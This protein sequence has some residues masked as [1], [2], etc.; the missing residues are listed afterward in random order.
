MENLSDH[1]TDNA[2]QWFDDHPRWTRHFT[3]K[4]ASWLNQVE[5]AFSILQSRVI[6]RGS[7]TSKDDLRDKIYAYLGWHNQTDQP[8]HWIGSN[9]Q[10]PGQTMPASLLTGGTSTS[11]HPFRRQTWRIKTLSSA[12]P[13]TSLGVFRRANLRLLDDRRST[14]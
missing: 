7:F 10:N 13:A 4:H 8:F 5:D 12:S 2:N 6:A 11:R 1:D 3:P 14:K 9:V